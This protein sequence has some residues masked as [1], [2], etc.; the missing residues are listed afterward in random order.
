MDSSIKAGLSFGLTSAIITTL[1]LMIG[2]DSATNSVMVVIGGIITISVADGLSD[3]LGMHISAESNKKNS[4]SSL[5]KI[6]LATFFTKLIFG[7]SFLIPI[8]LFGLRTAIIVN[9]FYGLFLLTILSYK[10]AKYNKEK[11]VHTIIEHLAIA[12][13]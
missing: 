8:F 9:I 7:L 12:I 11:P 4:K 6:A 10:I 13:G 2:L 1:G 5:L 3:S